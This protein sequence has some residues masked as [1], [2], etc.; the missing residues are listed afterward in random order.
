MYS[1]TH[2]QAAVQT[3]ALS[4]LLTCA[5]THIA[6]A[7]E[8]NP[9]PRGVLIPDPTPRPP[10]LQ[11]DYGNDPA[12]AKKQQ[13]LMALKNQLRAREIWLDVNKL[14]LYAQELKAEVSIHEK[15]SPM[16]TNS[17]KAGEIEKL[18]KEV[19]EKLKEH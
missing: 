19:K 18:A 14:L 4:I 17:I 6:A 8:G 9:P 7:Q 10:D 1:L 3:C 2:L 13:E 11:R 16:T 15:G 12:Q 5:T